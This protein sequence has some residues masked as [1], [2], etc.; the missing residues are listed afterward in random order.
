M[1]RTKPEVIGR[2]TIDNDIAKLVP[3]KMRRFHP[4]DAGR[5]GFGEIDIHHRTRRDA[6]IQNM[7]DHL[8]AI[9][10]AC[11]IIN[12]VFAAMTLRQRD[13]WHAKQ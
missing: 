12:R 7:A 13:C 1:Q 5:I 6:Q 8:L 4:F 9:K 10:P 11:S 3:V 2:A